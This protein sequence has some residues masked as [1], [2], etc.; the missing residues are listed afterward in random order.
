MK[1]YYSTQRPV[2]PGSI[3]K[4]E[5]NQILSVTNYGKR[6][7]VEAIGR[8]AWGFIEYEKPLTDEAAMSYELVSETP[9]ATLWYPVTV[10]SRKHGG[11]LRV[12]S[13]MTVRAAQRPDD[14]M[15]E[16][17]KVQFKT[18]YFSSWPEA[19]RIMHVIQGLHITVER[20]R[21]S[22]TQGECKIYFNGQYI[23][24]TQDEITCTIKDANPENYYGADIGGWRSSKPDS[25]SILGLIWHPFDHVYH[26]SDTICSKLGIKLEDWING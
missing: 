24:S 11:G 17:R 18:R 6:Q 23:A 10:S 4:P 20:V 3:P 21:M 12:F 15:G 2:T 26:F 13:G 16:T 8:A 1:K 9:G 5:G 25:A 22:A 7:Y 14:T 19:Q